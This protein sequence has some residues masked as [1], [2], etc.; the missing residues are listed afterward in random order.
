MYLFLLLKLMV[1]TLFLYWVIIKLAYI[2]KMW[3]ILL[4]RDKKAEVLKY[5][6]EK[7]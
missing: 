7:K 3:H 2:G 1:F 4:T 6:H 5:G